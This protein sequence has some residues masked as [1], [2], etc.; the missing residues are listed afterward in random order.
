MRLI[1]TSIMGLFLICSL[2]FS[3][4]EISILG[5]GKGNNHD[6]ALTAAKRDAIEKGIKRVFS[7]QIEY[8]CY[9]AERD[10]VLS[11]SSD[12]LKKFEIISEKKENNSS[13]Q[14]QIKTTLNT[15]LI[16]NGLAELQITIESMAKPK[17]LVV[18]DES[19]LGEKNAE[20]RAA[21]SAISNYFK[22]LTFDVIEGQAVSAI[23]NSDQKMAYLEGEASDAAS[24]GNQF[25]AEVI[26]TGKAASRRVD[27]LN[28]GSMISAQADVTLKVINCSTSSILGTYTEHAVSCHLSPQNA[29][30]QAISEAAKTGAGKLVDLIMKNWRDQ[31][32]NGTILNL[33]I[34]NISIFRIKNAVIQTIKGI[35]GVI[36][37]HERNWDSQN[38][39]LILDIQYKG[40]P[41]VFNK[42]IDGYKMK[43]GG[44]SLVVTGING[45]SILLSA[46]AM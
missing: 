44:G 18:I 31:E 5:F 32:D 16:K 3:Q 42:K 23:K 22:K 11:K 10:M 1:F 33:T 26:I 19:N 12:F 25:G 13:I 2:S 20:N 41:N 45:Q 7:T 28:V 27:S 29:G 37:V 6:E 14:I 21:E 24:I 17:L 30:V 35:N 8:E 9:L 34:S 39:Q 43:S 36:G 46:Q 4:E 40:N 38:N 15:H